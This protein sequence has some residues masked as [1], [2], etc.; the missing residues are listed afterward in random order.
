MVPARVVVM[1]LSVIITPE[2]RFSIPLPIGDRIKAIAYPGLVSER[3]VLLIRL[4][5]I[6]TLVICAVVPPVMP[7]LITLAVEVVPMLVNVL[8][9]MTCVS[10]MALFPTVMK[11]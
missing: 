11:P 5:E 8:S 1:L 9:L 6:I 3:L 2:N 10:Q 7:I 4:P